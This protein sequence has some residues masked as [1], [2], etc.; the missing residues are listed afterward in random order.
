M[1]EINNSVTGADDSNIRSKDR[2]YFARI[3]YWF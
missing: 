3:W 2:L 1:P